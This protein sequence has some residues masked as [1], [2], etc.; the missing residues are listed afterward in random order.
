LKKENISS[1]PVFSEDKQIYVGLVDMLD[2]MGV[3]AL[4][5]K[6]ENSI[7]D[8]HELYNKF[9]FSV[10]TVGEIIAQSHRSRNIVILDVGESIQSAMDVLGENHRLL[11]R[12]R[13]V[14]TGKNTF[15]LLSQMDIVKYLSKNINLG[16]KGNMRLEQL[17]LANPLGSEVIT[18]SKH[19]KATNAFNII[20]REQIGAVAVV[21]D[22]GVLLANLSISDLMGISDQNIGN[23]MLP[24]LEFLQKTNGERPA[25]PVTCKATDHL[26]DILPKILTAHVHRLWVTNS[27]QKAIGVITLTDIINVVLR[28]PPTTAL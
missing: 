16:S 11:I 3:T 10:D 28:D 24:V 23:V 15:K 13:D 21:D 18:V 9:A 25:V 17:G 6:D 19:T 2:V 20:Y 5:I 8:Y 1:V 7:L 14:N 22:D 4:G 27:A 12:T 26:E